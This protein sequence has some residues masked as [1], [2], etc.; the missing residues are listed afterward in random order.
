MYNTEASLKYFAAQ[1]LASTT[2]L[3]IAAVKTLTEDFFSFETNRYT[4]T[5][6][7]TPLLLKKVE[8]PLFTD[9]SQE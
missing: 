8:Q 1:V 5:V 3:F 7:C 4:P 9:D 6:I 2:L